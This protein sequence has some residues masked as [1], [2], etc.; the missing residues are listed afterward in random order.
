MMGQLETDIR[1]TQVF[2]L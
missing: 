2:G 1:R